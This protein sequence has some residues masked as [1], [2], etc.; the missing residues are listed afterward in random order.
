MVFQGHKDI[1]ENF[2]I[3]QDEKLLVSASRDHTLRIW[4]FNIGSTSRIL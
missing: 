2:A 1:I 3:T 4:N